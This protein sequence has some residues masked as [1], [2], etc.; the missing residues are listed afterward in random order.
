MHLVGILF[1]HINDDERSESRQNSTEISEPYSRRVFSHTKSTCSSKFRNYIN[2]GPSH[3][4]YPI[5]RRVIL[6]LIYIYIYK[7]HVV[8]TEQNKKKKSEIGRGL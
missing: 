6:I 7:I 4:M 1:P 5:Q 8:N 2:M 3:K